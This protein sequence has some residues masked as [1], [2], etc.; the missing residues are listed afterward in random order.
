MTTVI[1]ELLCYLLNKVDSVP[2]D[3]LMRLI[4]ENFNDAE[5]DD[6]KVLL[7]S[8]VDESIKAG[9]RR[10]QNKKSL[11]IQDIIKMLIECD[12]DNLPK[13]VALNLAKLPP[14]SI[15]CI[16]VSCLLRKQQLMEVE[17]CD[18]RKM[19]DD[20]LKVTVDTSKKVET[21]M[22]RDPAPSVV[23]PQAAND[24]PF[25]STDRHGCSLNRRGSH[26][27]ESDGGVGAIPRERSRDDGSEGGAGVMPRQGSRADECPSSY[28]SIA[29]ASSCQDE[30]WQVANRVKKPK[31]APPSTA[32]RGSADGQRAKQSTR[33]GVIGLQKTD[34]IRAVKA[35]KR[36]SIFVSRLPP[37]TGT[38]AIKSYAMEQVKASSVEVTQLKTKFDTYESYRLDIVD[39]GVDDV[40]DPQLW[41]QGLII[42][43]FFDKKSD[44]TASKTRAEVRSFGN[45]AGLRT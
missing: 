9:N 15:D 27:D 16:D 12:R 33:K 19:I 42:R 26:D 21:V 24:Q 30:G 17:M 36:M 44:S 4:N 35:T 10:G 18:M 11:N 5:V 22:L 25:S 20:I 1:N 7:C 43:R 39:P 37:G 6:A 28:A 8:H 38:E 29:A 34:A 45:E 31:A 2:Q 13:F 3:T 32:G 40:L 14:I 23:A 41:A